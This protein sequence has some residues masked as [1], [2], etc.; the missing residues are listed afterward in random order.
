[1]KKITVLFGL[2]LLSSQIVSATETP[3][4]SPCLINFEDAYQKVERNYAGWNQKLSKSKDRKKF[5]K[6]SAET[7]KKVAAI[8]EPEACYFAI[9]EWL[10]F[11]KDGHL[12]IN[13]PNPYVKPESQSDFQKRV[14]SVSF[15][16]F[17]DEES[18]K[19]FIDSRNNHESIVGIWETDDKNYRLGITGSGK[20][21]EFQAFL[22]NDR[23]ENWK[24]GKVKIEIKKSAADKYVSN[25]YYADFHSE[26]KFTRLI[27]N[28]LVIDDVYKLRKVYPEPEEKVSNEDLLTRLPDYRVEKINNNTVYIKLPPFTMFEA[29]DY[30]LD[31][32]NKNRQLISMTENLIID[33]RNNPGGDENAFSAFYPFIADKPI[34]RKGGTFRASEENLILL[35]HEL[36]SIQEYPKYKRILAPKLNEVIALMHNNMGKEFNGPDKVFQYV[37]PTA[38]PAKVAVLVNENTASSA[39]SVVLEAKQSNKTVVMG[40]RTKGLADYIEVRDWG[41]P[42]YGW[43]LAVGMAKANRGLEIDNKGI[44]PDVKVP[45][46]EADWINFASEY[47]NTNRK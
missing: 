25:Y 40:T 22:L 38:Y 47:L 4:P 11:F 29:A 9:T 36:Q 39:E 32:V 46:D 1:M 10:S 18:F 5:N 16:S 44:K 27:K 12:F 43:R 20:T 8:E 26:K 17:K 34:V 13:I 6:L 23:D 2:M 15:A 41:M 14:A 31:M 35:S 45:K 33:L 30:I 3:K 24:A 7:R 28:Y 19:K 42:K 37:K 21:G